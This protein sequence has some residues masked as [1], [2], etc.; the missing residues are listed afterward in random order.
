MCELIVRAGIV[1]KPDGSAYTADEIWNLSPQGELT[2]VFGW[3]E[4]ARK[5]LGM[6]S[7]AYRDALPDPTKSACYP[8]DWCELPDGSLH[9]FWGGVWRPMSDWQNVETK[10]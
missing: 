5:K 7:S 6:K 1:R 8:G 9:V 10:I 3:Y 2:H 4:A